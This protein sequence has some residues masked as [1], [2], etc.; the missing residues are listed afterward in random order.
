M[1]NND[2]QSFPDRMPEDGNGLNAPECVRVITIRTAITLKCTR[3]ARDTVAIVP[4]L[5]SS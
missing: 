2:G 5:A 4:H 3:D 1:G